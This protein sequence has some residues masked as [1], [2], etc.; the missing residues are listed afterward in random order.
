MKKLSLLVA[1][2][3][4]L[5]SSASQALEPVAIVE[6]ASADAPVRT[7]SYLSQG[8]VIKLGAKAEL[9][10]G[11]LTSCV[12]ERV[13]G[14]VVKIGQDRSHVTNGHRSEK[15]LDCGGAAK[16]SRAES[17]RGAALVIR[18]PPVDRAEDSTQVDN[19]L[20]CAETSR[21]RCASDPPRPQGARHEIGAS[22][23][24]VAD[25]AAMGVALRRGGTYRVKAGAASTVVKIA[26]DA[27]PGGGPILVRLLS[28]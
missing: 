18:K 11:Y 15:L 4:L 9:L 27:R 19:S 6:E 23:R 2:S 12:Q 5:F 14:G 20:H 25:L 3:L 28:F 10:I 26:P 21:L 24:G 1:V 8:Q 22:K 17:E 13:L 16:L 7:F